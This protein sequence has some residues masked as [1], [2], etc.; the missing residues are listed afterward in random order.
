MQVRIINN[1]L[2]TNDNNNTTV[3][4]LNFENVMGIQSLY[5]FLNQHS[6]KRNQ[7]MFEYK[8]KIRSMFEISKTVTLEDE[9][10]INGQNIFILDSLGQSNEHSLFEIRNYLDVE[11]IEMLVPREINTNSTVYVHFK[12]FQ[13]IDRIPEHLQSNE[14]KED[15]NKMI[16]WIL[17]TDEIQEYQITPFKISF[18]FPIHVFTPVLMK[19]FTQLLKVYKE[20]LKGA[21]L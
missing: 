6:F 17:N 11:N 10:I 20:S 3:Q 7:T 4:K 8:E 1:L 19:H 21:S 5:E 16:R 13:S 18:A 15:W 12:D 14:L 2:I 9:D